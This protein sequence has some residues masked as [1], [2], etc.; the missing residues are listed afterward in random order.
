MNT[1]LQRLLDR[2][3]PSM[4]TGASLLPAGLSHSP[5][6]LSDQRLND[7]GFTDRY[8]S[9]PNGSEQFENTTPKPPQPTQRQLPQQSSAEAAPPEPAPPQTAE[10]SQPGSEPPAQQIVETSQQTPVI[11]AAMPSAKHPWPTGLVEKSE[12]ILPEPESV[13]P[14]PKRDEPTSSPPLDSVP[15]RMQTEP[16]EATLAKPQEIRAPKQTP[17]EFSEVTPAPLRPKTEPVT[18]PDLPGPRQTSGNFFATEPQPL[19]EAMPAPVEVPALPD[20]PLP[21]QHQ[22]GPAP[23]PPPLVQ[24]AQQPSNDIPLAEARRP[25]PMT[26]NGASIIGQL[27][28]RRRALTIFG[29]RRR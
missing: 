16:A 14:A 26:A 23:V 24:V 6:S 20:L 21:P 22:P 2:T 11:E 17:V 28:P 15:T 25:R 29:L 13:E 9:S 3:T 7:P 5:I 1:Y 10:H 27:T 18:A 4:Q 8:T 12:L 19:V